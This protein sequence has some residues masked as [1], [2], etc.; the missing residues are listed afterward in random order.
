MMTSLLF[1]VM[2]AGCEQFTGKSYTG[3]SNVD[4]NGNGTLTGMVAQATAEGF[5]PVEG[6]IVE[7]LLDD[8]QAMARSS[9]SNARP[10]DAVVVTST[11]TN[12]E[13]RFEIAN[14]A[15]GTYSIRVTKDGF[16]PFYSGNF[17]FA[18]DSAVN[19]ELAADPTTP[20]TE[21]TEPKRVRR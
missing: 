8:S 7:L 21:P 5:A 1:L 9:K 18:T 12:I 10:S 4:T 6:A 14:V 16:L 19:A 11:M 20:P 3:P 17:Q 15:Y 2:A 13:G